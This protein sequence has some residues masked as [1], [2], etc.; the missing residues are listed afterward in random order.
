MVAMVASALTSNTDHPRATPENSLPIECPSSFEPRFEAF[1]KIGSSGDGGVDRVEGS[2]ANAK[3]RHQVVAW[4]KEL[5]FEVRIDGIG[6]VYGLLALAGADAPWI[7]TGSH[8][9]SQ[10]LG[11]RF[12]G[13]YGVIAGIDAAAAVRDRLAASGQKAQANLA[14]VAWAGEEGAR[15][16]PFLGSRVF[17]GV[18]SF[19]ESLSGTDVEGRTAREALE[20]IGFLGTDDPPPR[21]AAYVELHVECGS[22]LEQQGYRL[23]IF[24]RWW[25]AHKLDIEFSGETAHTGPTPMAKRRDALFAA[26]QVITGIR[27]L[28]DAAPAGDLHTS[29]G[30]LVVVPNSPN[31]VPCLATANVELRSVKPDVLTA[32]RDRLMELASFAAATARV[33]FRIVRDDLRVPGAFDERLGSLARHAAKAIGFDPIDAE[34]LPGHDAIMLAA[35]CPTLMLTVPSRD[36]LCHHP[37]EWTDPEDLKLGVAWLG[38]VLDRLVVDGPEAQT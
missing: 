31:V 13:A 2:E 38:T 30:K 26:A 16:K 35:I 24:T 20:A 1:S 8:I 11:G 27:H 37:L 3:A 36:G 12:D 28:A 29:V 25:G 14:V 10:P 19:E 4:M 7:M 32:S 23:G 9:D 17:T 18:R 15:F 34:T 22:H 21:P 33:T 6:N 5:G